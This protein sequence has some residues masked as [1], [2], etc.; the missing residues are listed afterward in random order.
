MK[1]APEN[2]DYHFF[3]RKFYLDLML[4]ENIQSG[5]QTAVSTGCNICSAFKALRLLTKPFLV[6]PPESLE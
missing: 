5:I 3:N 4:S 6:I 1:I 2:P